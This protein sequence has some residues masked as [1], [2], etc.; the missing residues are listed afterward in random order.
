VDLASLAAFANSLGSSGYQKLPGGV[1]I[2][3]GFAT[4]NTT[5]NFPIAFPTA[6]GAVTFGLTTGDGI[7]RVSSITTSSFFY[8]SARSGGSN[9]YYIA[10]GY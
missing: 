2:Q 1:I 9:A 10:I 8:E 6:V 3:W 7:P 5:V 4:W